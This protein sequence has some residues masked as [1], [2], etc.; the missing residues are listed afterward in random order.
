M[1]RATLACVLAGLLA[2]PARSTP[3]EPGA[4]A[5]ATGATG[6]ERQ[7]PPFD[8]RLPREAVLEPIDR[9]VGYLLERQREDG[10]WGTPAPDCLMEL[11]FALES[12]YSWRL[13]A[14]GLN[15]MALAAVPETPERREALDRAVLWLC[16]TRLSTRGSDW[17]C[18][19]VW[20]ALYGF[21]ACL[22]LLE[23]PR[24]QVEPWDAMLDR[25]GRE[26]LEILRRYQAL[27][28]G[29]AYY[30]SPP[31]DRT[32]TWATSFCT[33]LV[34]PYLVDARKRGWEVDERMI[35]RAR[36]YVRKCAL[37]NGAYSYDLNP[38]VRLSGVE[39]INLTEG[40]L[41][42]IHSLRPLLQ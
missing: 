1:A 28:G 30:D 40:S 2:A 7:D 35:E 32:L 23:D 14:Q 41:G 5:S 25:R 4:D 18:D 27:S 31:Y 33:A 36:K 8:E 24:F 21:V 37:P 20:S 29:W 6:T 9:A 17:D 38:V 16:D 10:S 12:Y 13:A 39:H 22:E 19:N 15:C 34:L 42:R 26:F 3:Q 11:G